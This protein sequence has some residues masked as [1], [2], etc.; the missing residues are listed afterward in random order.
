MDSVRL[1]EE[2]KLRKRWREL[3]LLASN[4][5]LWRAGIVDALCPIEDL[6]EEEEGGAQ[7]VK[8]NSLDK[9]KKRIS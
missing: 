1:G 3:K 8:L 9:F 5:I 6:E 4:R 7:F 2:Q